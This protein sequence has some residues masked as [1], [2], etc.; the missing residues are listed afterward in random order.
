MTAS[1]KWRALLEELEPT[2]GRWRR[3]ARVGLITALGAGATAAMQVTNPLGLTLLF[4]FALPEAAF[5]PALGA[6][7]ICSAAV[8]QALGLV[9]I[10]ALVNSPVIHV[11]V[12]IL[13]CLV[14]TYLIYAVPTLGRLWVWIQVPVVTA[15]YLAMFI[16]DGLL[17]NEAQAFSGIAIAVAILLLCNAVMRPEPAESVLANSIA[18]T[19]ARSS[20]RLATLVEILLG[21]VPAV[22]ERPVASRL[23]Y[24]LSLLGHSI[25]SARDAAS[26]ATL[27]A[28]VLVAEGIRGQIDRMAAVALANER[29]P[30][31]TGS[32]DELRAL[33]A[34]D[35][36]PARAVRSERAW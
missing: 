1:G 16:P 31:R 6:V 26:P 32:A 3:A 7:F 28:D 19:L 13:L 21:E 33:G 24:H 22:D 4:N 27:L 34:A 12:F 9:L 17:W 5:S 29:R 25:T 36:S 8:L 30:P 15:F 20:T 2:P 14:T 35:Q 11:T 10:G 23:G 18:A